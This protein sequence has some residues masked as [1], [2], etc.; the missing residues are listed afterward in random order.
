MAFQAP[1]ENCPAKK[2]GTASLYFLHA[3]STVMSQEERRQTSFL[4][5]TLSK[6]L[7]VMIHLRKKTRKYTDYLNRLNII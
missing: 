3:R 7:E 6:G 2:V 4:M 1:G 5:G